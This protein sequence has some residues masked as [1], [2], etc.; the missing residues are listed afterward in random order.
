MVVT[1]Q[2]IGRGHFDITPDDDT[3]LASVATGGL[4]VG[5]AGDV[6]FR[7]LQ[8]ADVTWTV[9]AGTFIPVAAVRVLATGTTAT[10]I[11]GIKA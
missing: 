2:L 4:F 7:D 11:I 3:D 5:G 10:S 6:C 8:G 9:A 1:P